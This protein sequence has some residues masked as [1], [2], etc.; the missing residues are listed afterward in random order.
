MN[1]SPFHTRT[2][3][4]M[5]L[6][7]AGEPPHEGPLIPRGLA[8]QRYEVCFMKPHTPSFVSSRNDFEQGIEPSLRIL[9]VHQHPCDWARVQLGCPLG[10]IPIARPIN[11]RHRSSLV[12]ERCTVH[13]YL[14]AHLANQNRSLSVCG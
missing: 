11:V 9:Q 10:E 3:G 4:V 5:T 8:V 1:R 7:A 13:F 12:E 6:W 2:V 14:S